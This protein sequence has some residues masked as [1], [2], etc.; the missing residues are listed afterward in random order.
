MHLGSAQALGLRARQRGIAAL[1]PR[2]GKV[3]TAALHLPPL[4]SRS[5][6]HRHAHALAHAPHSPSRSMSCSCASDS[7]SSP[8]LP[9]IVLITF[10]FES[11]Y[12][13]LMLGSAQLFPTSSPC[14]RLWPHE[15][16]VARDWGQLRLQSVH[17]C[18]AERK[19]TYW[20]KRKTAAAVAG[21]RA[22][23]MGPW[24]RRWRRRG[25]GGRWA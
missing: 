11:V 18:P 15:V 6:I 4:L 17:S 19:T 24:W 12:V 25:G 22:Q 7:R 16:A 10:P 20:Q 3:G 14:P 21:R 2:R 13:T 8:S 23:A 9:S 1:P 5:G